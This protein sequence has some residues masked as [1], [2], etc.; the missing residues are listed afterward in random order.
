VYIDTGSP[1]PN[2]PSKS[3][4]LADENKKFL[5]GRNGN[6]SRQPYC[7]LL[8]INV[9]ENR[10]ERTI[11]NV[12]FKDSGNMWHKTQNENKRSKKTQKTKT[13]SNTASTQKPG[14][15]SCCR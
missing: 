5:T 2:I 14:V 1:V 13:R 12:Q 10:R 11:K 4:G 8:L 3:R 7:S 9:R 6:D 15:I